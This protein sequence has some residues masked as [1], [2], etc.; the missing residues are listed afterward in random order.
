MERDLSAV[1]VRVLASLVEKAA[2]TPDN[3]P[4]SSNALVAAC[5]QKTSRDPVVDFDERTVDAAMIT[6]RERGLARTVRGGTSRVVKHRHVLDEALGLDAA[7]LAVMSVLALRGPQTPGELRTRGE[8][9]HAFADLV[10]VEETLAGLAAHEPS[11]VRDVGRQPGQKETRFAHLLSE[12]ADPDDAAPS[13]DPVP[14]RSSDGPDAV[15]GSEPSPRDR[16]TA[17]AEL[18]DLRAQ[19]VQLRAEMDA[20]RATVDEL[21]R[22]LGLEP[23]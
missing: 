17:S 13:P 21:R 1:E 9:Q 10:E 7:E 16:A 22:E 15:A 12:D 8:R 6:L 4:L 19:V 5:N 23:G 18:A 11:L 20:L 2:T 14:P 3:Y